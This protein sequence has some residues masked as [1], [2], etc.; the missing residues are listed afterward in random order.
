MAKSS[1]EIKRKLREIKRLEINLRFHGDANEAEG[2]L[3]WDEF[4]SLKSGQ[5]SSSK[6]NLKT[7][8]K[9]NRDEF[10]EVLD[11]YFYFVYF[12]NY[13]ERGLSFVNLYDPNLLGL[14]GLPLSATE[15]EIKSKFRELA[16]KYHPDMG[17]DAEKFMELMDIY[18]QLTDLNP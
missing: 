1:V 8:E 7:L 2:S 5:N 3:V 4:F 18:N 11:E 13:Q 17:G 15:S 14:L 16:K 10:K 12:R 6:Y 9:M